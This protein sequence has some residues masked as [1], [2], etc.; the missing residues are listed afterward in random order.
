MDDTQLFERLIGDFVP[1]RVFDVHA[2]LYRVDQL[3]SAVAPRI[4]QAWDVA[5]LAAWR[6]AQTALLGDRAPRNGL[7]F[8]WPTVSLDTTAANQFLV[9]ELR[10]HP[11]SRP[12]MMIRP[13]DD[14]STL[15]LDAGFIGFKVYHLY[16]GLADSRDANAGVAESQNATIDQ[17]LPDWAWRIAHERSWVIMLHIVRQRSLADPVNTDTIREKCTQ[18][19]GAKLILAH[20]ARGFAGPHTVEGIERL[21]GLDNVYFDT[22]VVCEPLPLCAILKVFG[23]GRLMYGSDFPASQWRGKPFSIGDGFYWIYDDSVD[24]TAWTLGQPTLTS[25]EALHALKQATELLSLADA[26]IQRIFYDNAAEL[27]GLE[28]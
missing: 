4:G 9:D 2:H 3:G 7:F 16:S 6:E 11:G 12:L 14:P 22:S 15:D 28:E 24:W 8:P 21:S 25:I 5:G 17:F 20:A 1:P 18:Y 26:D 10:A 23:P 13:D 19:P 27:L